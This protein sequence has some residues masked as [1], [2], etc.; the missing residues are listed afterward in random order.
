MIG[1]LNTRPR[2]QGGALSAALAKAGFAPFDVPLVDL[3]LLDDALDLLG[4]LSAEHYDGILLS[5]PNLLPLLKSAGRDV[6]PAWKRKPWYLIGSRARADVEALGPPPIDVAFVPRDPSLEGFLR[7][8][9]AVTAPG[10]LRLIH[11]CSSKTR[12]EPALFAAKGLHVHNMAVYEPR[13]PEGA[14]AAVEQAWPRVSEGGAV[15]FASGSAVHH[16]FQAAPLRA[17]DLALD[18]GPLPVSIGAS[19]TRA[20][21]MYGVDR[22]VQAPTADNAGFIAALQ[23]IFPG[24]PS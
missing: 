6:P 17:R 23:S 24:N 20:L 14:A 7:E 2:D 19:T 9:P 16:L 5:S 4:R 11:P 22:F 21:R 3:A 1:V 10:G 8:F 12:L 13:C 18:R 15:L